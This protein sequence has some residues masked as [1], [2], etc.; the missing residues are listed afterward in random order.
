MGNLINLN[1][2]LEVA[3]LGLV[4]A[5]VPVGIVAHRGRRQGLQGWAAWQRVLTVLALF[6]TLDL[7]VFGAFTRLTDS[8][9]GCPDW[10]GC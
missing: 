9:L 10:P 3:L 2:A 8:G 1:P 4:L 6:L 7:V 5:L